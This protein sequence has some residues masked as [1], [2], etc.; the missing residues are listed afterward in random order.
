METGAGSGLLSMVPFTLMSLTVAVVANLL[1]REK[2]RPVAVW[3]LLGFIPLVNFVCIWYFV[4]A[5]NLHLESK[6]DRILTALD[7]RNIP[8]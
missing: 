4:G 2:G 3:T 5:A 8:L 1:A 6:L 7:K